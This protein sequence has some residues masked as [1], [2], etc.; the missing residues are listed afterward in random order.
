M[1]LVSVVVVTRNRPCEFRR[2]L[3]SLAGQSLRPLEVVIVD[4]GSS[5]NYAPEAA[6]RHSSSTGV[7]FVVV[8]SPVNI[9]VPAARNLGSERSTGDFIVWLDD[10]ARFEHPWSLEEIRRV[11][12]GPCAPPIVAYPVVETVG[13]RSR[14]LAPYRR[15]LPLPDRAVPTS[16]FLG[17]ASAVRRDFF[18]ARGKFDP[19]FFYQLEELEFSWRICGMQYRILLLPQVRVLHEPAAEP[20]RRSRDFVRFQARNRIQVVVRYLPV[21]PAVVHSAV[22]S[23]YLGI[24]AFRSG[25]LWHLVVGL[26]EAFAVLPRSI[27]MRPSHRFRREN[28]HHLAALPNRL[29]Y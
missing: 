3:D 8:R 13:E 14:T 25:A 1:S 7:D 4:N 27:R 5:S 6:A 28:W 18:V 26:G 10:D 21:V 9:G 17:S 29:W 12:A 19:S 2:C 20:V 24:L 15:G 16:F 22:W 11:M 23:A